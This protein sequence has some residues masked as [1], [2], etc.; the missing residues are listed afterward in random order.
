MMLSAV[1][2]AGQPLTGLPM[3]SYESD[4]TVLAGPCCNCN[5]MP[6]WLKAACMAWTS[7]CNSGMPLVYS[8]GIAS[9]VPLAIPAPHSLLAVPGLVQV[10]VPPGG[11]VQPCAV[12]NCLAAVGLNGYGLVFSAG[13]R[14]LLAGNVGTGP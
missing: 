11:I 13:S 14:K 9:L 3:H 10:A 6:P 7:S 12:S 4:R 5:C 2:L 8:I 1:E